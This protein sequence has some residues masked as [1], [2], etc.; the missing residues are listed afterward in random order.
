MGF[1]TR[2]AGPV[3]A[4]EAIPSNALPITDEQ[5]SDFVINQGRSQPDLLRRCTGVRRCQAFIQ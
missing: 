5:W 2:T 4:V 3:T 1:N